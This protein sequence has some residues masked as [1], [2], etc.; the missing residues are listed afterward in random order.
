MTRLDRCGRSPA[1]RGVHRAALLA[2]ACALAGCTQFNVRSRQ[3]PSTDFSRLRTWAWL[4][5]SEAAPADQ[6][7]LNRL[8]DARIQRAVESELRAKGYAAADGQADFLLNYRL[9]TQ[10]ASDVKGDPRRAFAD[11]FWWGIPDGEGF[12]T[13]SYDEGTLY[14]AILDAATKRIVWVGAAGARLVPTMSM[15]KTEKRVDEAVQQIM[16][17]FPA[18]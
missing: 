15:E 13:E 9:A 7:T 18:R 8:I 12:Y 11:S 3:D 17:R 5:L 2:I 4:P 16:A 1:G 14:V 10:P 6:R